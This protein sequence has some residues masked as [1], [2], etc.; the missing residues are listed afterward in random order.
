MRSGKDGRLESGEEEHSLT[1]QRPA[2]VALAGP[3]A[4]WHITGPSPTTHNTPGKPRMVDIQRTD[5]VAVTAP[6]RVP[7]LSATVFVLPLK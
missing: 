5:G 3:A 2:R 7:A 1:R 4:R 6:L